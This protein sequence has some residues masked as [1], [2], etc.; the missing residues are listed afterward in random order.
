M[1]VTYFNTSIF[2]G[3]FFTVA[4]RGEVV[5]QAAD[6]RTENFTKTFFLV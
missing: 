4:E 3:Y 1:H 6:N 2:L 5:D